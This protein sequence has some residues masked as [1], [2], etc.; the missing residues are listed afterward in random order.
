MEMFSRSLP[1]SFQILGFELKKPNESGI[2]VYWTLHIIQ[3]WQ[4]YVLK[5]EILGRLNAT[6]SRLANSNL[7]QATW[8]QP[9]SS[10]RQMPINLSSA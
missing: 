2:D 1:W 6:A 8:S 5:T 7:D 3:T 10:P 9:K 4:F